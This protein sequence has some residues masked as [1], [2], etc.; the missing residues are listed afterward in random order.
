VFAAE[1]EILSSPN[2]H[3]PSM[4]LCFDTMA[5]A[6][7]QLAR[8][9]AQRMIKLRTTHLSGLPRYL[10]PLGGARC[11]SMPGGRAK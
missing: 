10:S 2:F 4:A 6:L 1:R 8:A 5:I 11:R 7:T 9:S 3:P